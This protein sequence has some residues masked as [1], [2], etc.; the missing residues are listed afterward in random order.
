MT[1]SP[2]FV[3]CFTDGQTTRMTVHTSLTKLDGERGC[4]WRSMPIVRA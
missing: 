3:A 2:T 1:N 4:G